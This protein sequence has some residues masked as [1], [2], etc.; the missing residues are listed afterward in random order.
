MGDLDE[1]PGQLIELRE[2]IRQAH[3]VVKDLRAATREAKDVR[4]SLPA[5]AKKAVE[6]QISAEVAA[7]LE[8]YNAALTKAVEDGTKA[9][10]A[11]FDTIEKM[12]L[13]EDAHSVRAGRPSVPQLIGMIAEAE[14][15]VPAAVRQ[16]ML[17]PG[18]RKQGRRA[19]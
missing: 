6:D 13:G 7:G 2:L 4:G 14:G 15:D 12:L 5:A 16:A 8:S 1:L 17:P 3:E 19:R 11:R 18:L 9:V 10:Y